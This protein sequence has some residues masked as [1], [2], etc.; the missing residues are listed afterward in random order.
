MKTYEAIILL[1]FPL[2][3]MVCTWWLFRMIRQINHRVER[4][5]LERWK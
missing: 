2:F 4:S 5:R 3:L 1:L